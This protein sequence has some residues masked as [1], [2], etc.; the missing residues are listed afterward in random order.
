[1]YLFLIFIL[2]WFK[3]LPL[4]TLAGSR[5]IHRVFLVLDVSVLQHHTQR[6]PASPDVEVRQRDVAWL[7]S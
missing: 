6:L 7:T 5:Q 2:T 3:A 4:G 1:M